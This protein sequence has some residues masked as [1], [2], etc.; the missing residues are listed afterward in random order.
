M[1]TMTMTMMIKLCRRWWRWQWWC[2]QVR[3]TLRLRISP[4]R[5][6]LLYQEILEV[7]I[8]MLNLMMM[9]VLVDMMM[10]MTMKHISSWMM[11]RMEAAKVWRGEEDSTPLL[12]FRRQGL[13][14]NQDQVEDE[15]KY[16]WMIMS[17]RLEP[18]IP[19][20]LASRIRIVMWK[21]QTGTLHVA[22]HLTFYF[23]Q[24]L[25]V[26]ALDCQYNI[27]ATKSCLSM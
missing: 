11:R 8:M 23:S 18:H 24:Y 15:E 2:F 5:E 3:D 19:L 26:V 17:L 21:T 16:G 1:M 25:T 27:T 7:I 12:L 6:S 4:G 13:H 10:M 14:H 9:M 22:M 20:F